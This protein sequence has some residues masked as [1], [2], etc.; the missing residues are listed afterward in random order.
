MRCVLTG[1]ECGGAAKRSFDPSTRNTGP[2][3]IEELRNQGILEHFAEN[4]GA[5]RSSSTGGFM[6]GEGPK[7]LEEG[8]LR[9]GAMFASGETSV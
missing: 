5:R 2:A 1:P 9:G 3:S 7:V 4:R 6:V 8:I